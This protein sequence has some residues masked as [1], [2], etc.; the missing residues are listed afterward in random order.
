MRKLL[1]VM[2]LAGML[3]G[4]SSGEALRSDRLFQVALLQSLR[5]GEYDG[6]VTVGELKAYGDTGIGTFQGVTGEM[7]VL[8]GTI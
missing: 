8:G 3:C 6:V 2:L 4:C 1:S 7:I 5:Q